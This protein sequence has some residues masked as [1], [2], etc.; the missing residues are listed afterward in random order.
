MRIL[1]VLTS[2]G[3]FGDLGTR[4]GFRFDELATAWFTFLAAGAEVVI[5]SP[6]GGAPP[7]D[8][9]SHDP[10]D[11]PDIVARFLAQPDAREALQDTIELHRVEASDFDAVFYPGGPGLIWDLADCAVSGGLLTALHA[12][13]RPMAFVSE[14]V[15]AL[16]RVRNEAGRPVVAGRDI[17]FI[18][19][20]EHRMPFVECDAAERALH[21]AGANIIRVAVGVSNVVRDGLLITGQNPGSA[22]AT[23]AALL[24][25]IAHGSDPG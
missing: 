18:S 17:A 15:A 25:A 2:H 19:V 5:A 1:I 22:A 16:C 14:G 8:P 7:I 11:P 4:T 20:A 9:N 13:G 24:A 6:T 10:T 23:A 12:A 21:E 3:D